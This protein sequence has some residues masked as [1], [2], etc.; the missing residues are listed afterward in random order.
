MKITF[1]RSDRKY[2]YI[3]LFVLVFL[4]ANGFQYFSNRDLRN[5]IKERDKINLKLEE[6]NESLKDA[7]LVI[8]LELEAMQ[9]KADSFQASER[10]YKN[11]YYATN[12]KLKQILGTYAGSSDDDKWDAFTN[13]LKE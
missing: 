1:E 3:G 12:K 7:S 10:I 13:S 11:R 4:A 5:D 8:E 6:T 2:I 9:V